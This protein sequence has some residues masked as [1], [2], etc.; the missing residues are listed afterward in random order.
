MKSNTIR[1]T[2]LASGL[3]TESLVKAMLYTQQNKIDK[4]VRKQQLYTWKQDAW[5]E[6]NKK[7]NSFNDNYVD[8]LRMKTT[9]LKTKVTTNNDKALSV[10][11]HSNIGNG[12]HKV[13]IKQLAT[14][15]Y[16][17]TEKSNVKI[18]KINGNTTLGELGVANTRPA[19]DGSVN[20]S[21]PITLQI[22]EA[23]GSPTITINSSTTIDDLKTQ[24]QFH[25]IDLTLDTN[26]NKISLKSANSDELKLKVVEDESS[27]LFSKLGIGSGDTLT[28]ASNTE[29]KGSQLRETSLL[30]TTTLGNILDSNGNALITAGSPLRINVNGTN[31]TL[32]ATDTVDS[33]IG[34]MKAV[35]SNLSISYDSEMK[36]FFVTSTATGEVSKA[37]I[38]AIEPETYRDGTDNAAEVTKSTNFLKALGIVYDRQDTTTQ[39]GKNALYSYNGMGN[40]TVDGKNYFESSSNDVKINGLEMTL[41]EVTTEPVTIQGSTNTDDLVAF[42]KEF[43]SEYNKLM[44]EINTKLTTKTSSNYEPLTDEEKEATT[45]ANVEK[46]EKYVKD[47]LFY[48]DSDLM[49]IRDSLRDT[50]SGVVNGNTKYKTLQSIGITTGNWR[51]NGK[52]YF[53]EDTFVKAIQENPEDVIN[54]FAGSGNQNE[55]VKEYMKQNNMTSE[56]DAQTAYNALSYKDKQKYLTSSQGIFNRISTN[57]SSFSKSNDFRSFGSYYNDKSL[58]EDLKDIADKI[59][60]LNQKYTTKEKALYKK[61]T[62]MEKMMSQLNSQQSY[63][64][65]MLG[66]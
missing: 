43:V 54:I 37:Q 2:G 58:K 44:E 21:D 62:A 51:E 52:L 6:M 23:D 14:S 3:D 61:F 24:L 20:A 17:M 5:K 49:Q 18:A 50:M 57:L 39:Q 13:E 32:N 8:K 41:K 59:Y 35:D 28:L 64:T 53:D 27:N 30:G 4:Q 63:L 12:I 48:R 47:G 38:K 19:G 56:A 25:N 66:A 42:M 60:E 34:K 15:A 22:G 10:S 33:M 29:V 45:E 1:F 9:F 46:I 40:T 36:Q 55:A 11:E 16:M 65:S 31:I 7:I 26:T